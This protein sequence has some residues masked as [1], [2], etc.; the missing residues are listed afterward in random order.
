M[1]NDNKPPKFGP[2]CVIDLAASGRWARW[3]FP[4]EEAQWQDP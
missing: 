1:S 3:R 2:S 4:H